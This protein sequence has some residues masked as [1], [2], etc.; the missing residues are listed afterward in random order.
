[1]NFKKHKTFSEYN[2]P[3][4]NGVNL[5]ALAAWRVMAPTPGM[6]VMGMEMEAGLWRDIARSYHAGLG[7]ICGPYDR[8]YGMDMRRYFAITGIAIALRTHA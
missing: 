1:M 3:T 6:A 5:W 7:N 8:S 4:Y 2:S